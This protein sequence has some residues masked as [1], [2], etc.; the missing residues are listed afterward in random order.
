MLKGIGDARMKVLAV[1]EHVFCSIVA[2]DIGIHTLNTQKG[3]L[4]QKVLVQM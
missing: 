3:N 1:Q 4:A 2:Q